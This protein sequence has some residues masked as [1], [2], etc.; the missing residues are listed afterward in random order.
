MRIKIQTKQNIQTKKNRKRDK[1]TT[2]ERKSEQ[3][4]SFLL[5]LSLSQSL[6]FFLWFFNLLPTRKE[7]QKIFQVSVSGGSQLMLRVML[8]LSQFRKLHSH[9]L[10]SV[11]SWKIEFGVSNLK[12]FSLHDYI[13]RFM[14][15]FRSEF[16]KFRVFFVVSRCLNCLR[17]WKNEI[18]EWRVCLFLSLYCFP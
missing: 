12:P 2:G 5:S 8:N 16:L 17:N 9:K 18:F 13:I 10:F 1:D 11:S 6:I 7:K 15:R 14:W 3:I 4:R